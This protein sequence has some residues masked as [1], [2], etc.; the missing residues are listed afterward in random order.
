MEANNSSM[1]EIFGEVIHTYSRG[2]AIE[3]GFLVDLMQDKMAE[4]ARQHYK[5][6]VA[7]TAAVFEIMRKAVENPRWCNDYA[8][9][10]HDMLWMS[11]TYRR[12]LDESTVLFRVI[13]TGAGRNK[14]HTF[15]LIVGP[16]DDFEPVITI[17]LPDES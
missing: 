15:K 6:P 11:R 5:Y 16:G 9:I 3:D 2:Q 14:Y 8:G 1:Q 13:I 12:Q 4:V 7:C 10:L 17:M